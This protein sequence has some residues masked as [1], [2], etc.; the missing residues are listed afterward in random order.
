MAQETAPSSSSVPS[1]VF[2]ETLKG[3]KWHEENL[4]STIEEEGGFYPVR[5]GENFE[6]YRFVVT[7]KLGWGG[8]STVWLARDRK[9][10]LRVL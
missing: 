9:Y 2:N 10:V 4:S 5:I 3:L 8:H 1:Y 6:T 7:K